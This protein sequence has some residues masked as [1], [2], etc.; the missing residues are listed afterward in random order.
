M[1]PLRHWRR[2]ATGALV[3]LLRMGRQA[4]VLLRNLLRWITRVDIQD[5]LLLA[6]LA[7]LAY[8]LWQIWK[9]L[10][11]VVIGGLLVRLAV[12]PITPTVVPQPEKRTRHG[13]R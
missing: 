4:L 6:G 1:T 12:W 7:L 2:G 9:P 10:P 3:L 5:V 13:A 11:Y 8:G